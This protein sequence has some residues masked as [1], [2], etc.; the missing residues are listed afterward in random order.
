MLGDK[1]RLASPVKI[2]L[3]TEMEY[4]LFRRPTNSRGKFL[5]ALPQDKSFSRMGN[6]DILIGMLSPGPPNLIFVLFF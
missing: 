4:G 1:S 3:A 5:G 6:A 2:M